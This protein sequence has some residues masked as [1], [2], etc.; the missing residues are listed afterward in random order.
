MIKSKNK[1]LS[2]DLDILQKHVVVFSLLL[3]LVAKP[4]Y[5]IITFVIESKFE[6]YADV[7]KE[8]KEEIEDNNTDDKNIHHLIDFKIGSFDFISLSYSDINNCIF[9]FNSD[10]QLPPPKLS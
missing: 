6:L 9:S 4:V 7:V 8:S 10:I 1:Y 3:M 2:F 5:T